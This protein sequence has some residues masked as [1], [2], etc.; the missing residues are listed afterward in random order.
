[1]GGF[2]TRRI[3]LEGSYPLEPFGDDHRLANLLPVQAFPGAFNASRALLQIAGNM[4]VHAP[5]LVPYGT[6]QLYGVRKGLVTPGPSY[7]VV[8]RTANKAPN[9]DAGEAPGSVYIEGLGHLAVVY[10]GKS[11][12]C[13][14]PFVGT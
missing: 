14:R 7:V 5:K 2:F 12:T 11:V 1:M 4:Q 10:V 9:P 6:A 8:V 3:D 13:A